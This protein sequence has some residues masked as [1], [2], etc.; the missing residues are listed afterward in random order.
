VRSYIG[1]LHFFARQYDRAAEYLESTVT[2][3]PNHAL[4]RH[5]LG[6]LYLAQGRFSEAIEQLKKAVVLSPEPSAHYVAMLGCAYAR[7]ARTKEARAVLNQLTSQAERGLVSAFDVASVHAAL[8]EKPA[9]M[10][11]LERGYAQRDVWLVELKAWPW[12][13]S[14]LAE[15]RFRS[16]LQRVS[17]PG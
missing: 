3:D 2:I 16:L 5:N 8:G 13:D 1:Q 10:S 4:V 15:P 6:E 14:L 7:A 11:W 12:F 17:V 9:A